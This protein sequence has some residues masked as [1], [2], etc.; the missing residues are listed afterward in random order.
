MRQVSN[1]YKKGADKGWWIRWLDP[2]TR[3][4]K[5]RRFPNKKLAEHARSILYAQLNSDVFVSA[6]RYPWP[7][8]REEFLRRYDLTLKKTTKKEAQMFLDRLEKFC[9]PA[10]TDQISQPLFLSYLE[11]RKQECDNPF[12]LNKDVALFKTFTRWLAR[13]R[14]CLAEFDYPRF[15]CPPPRQKALSD[16]QIAALLGAC[17]TRAWQLRIV[18]ALSTGLRKTDLYRLP[19]AAVDLADGRVRTTEKKTRKLF[20]RPLPD[21]L[22]EALKTYAAALPADRPCFFEVY[23]QQWL[24]RQFRDFRPS[25]QITIQSLRKTYATRI[26][27]TAVSAAALNHS[28]PAVTRTFYSDM[29]YIRYVRVNQLPVAAWLAVP[30]RDKKPDGG[31]V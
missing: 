23:N 20:D 2:A 21:L 13:Q 25:D 16:S 3:R 14:Y 30:I 29:D 17:P 4:H 26:E 24:D 27:S 6:I 22:V 10:S 5:T 9:Y 31:R 18:L 12:T 8:A 15:K 11:K 1:P 28:S 7:A 19:S